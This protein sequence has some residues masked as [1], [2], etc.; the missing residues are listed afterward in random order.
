M[1][2][3]PF[4]LI[5]NQHFNSI[6]KV[7]SSQIPVLFLHGTADSI[8]NY[9]IIQ[10]TYSATPHPKQLFLIPDTEK[11]RLYQSKK[12]YFMCNKKFR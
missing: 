11:L 4:E 5:L 8:V 2:L 3:F 7:T 1:R 10:K 9:K 6:N 12:T